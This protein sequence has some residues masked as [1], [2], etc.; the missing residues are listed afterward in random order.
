MNNTL[1]LAEALRKKQ[2]AAANTQTQNPFRI[3]QPNP[4]QAYKIMNGSDVGRQ[5]LMMSAQLKQERLKKGLTQ[6]QLAKIC[7]ISQGTIARAE[8]GRGDISYYTLCKIAA[9]LEKIIQLT[10][11]IL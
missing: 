4:I 6:R 1:A 7:L 2:E 8:S 3:P 5:I 9:G 11:K 10:D